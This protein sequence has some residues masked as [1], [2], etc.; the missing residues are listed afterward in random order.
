M[1]SPIDQPTPEAALAEQL[2][3]LALEIYCRLAIE[4][5]Q[6]TP[7]ADRDYSRVAQEAQQAARAYFEQMGVQF[8]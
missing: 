4:H 5:I 7:E 3:D 1:P 8:Q 2:Q 6:V